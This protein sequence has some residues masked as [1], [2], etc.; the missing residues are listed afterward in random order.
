MVM[1]G[2]D[3]SN[4]QRGLDLAKM[5]V[6]FAI[7]K[8]T[9]GLDY[10]DSYCDGWVKQAKKLSMPWGFYHFARENDPVKE[11]D[12]FYKSCKN[13]FKSGIP[14]LDYETS[15]RNDVT[16]CEKFLERI[17]DLTGVWPLL[18]ISA[19]RVGTYF[20]SWIPDKCGLWIAGYPT[21][22]TDW[23]VYTNDGQDFS[24]YIKKQVQYDYWLYE[25]PPYDFG[26]WE[27]AAIWQFSSEVILSGYVGKLD[28]D[29]AYMDEN[30]WKKY[31]QGDNAK[32]TPTPKP[33][34]DKNTDE[35]A[36]E[37]LEGKHGTGA[38]RKKSLGKRY[39]EVQKR[40]D[41]LYNIAD[42]VIAGKWGNNETRKKK[43]KAAGYPYDLV[44][45]IVNEKMA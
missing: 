26:K 7:F 30:A 33:T 41:E 38:K 24:H 44:Q 39:D 22:Y 9:E 25:T 4:W 40:I 13:Y 15:N 17:H 32:P 31:A 10:V 16:W 27:C 2:I 37:V 18:Y 23:P 19:Y 1:R 14:V 20:N 36:R 8:A 45:K 3:I 21:T 6:D 29:L 28:G 35:L 42:E 34:Y 5:P 11:A 12:F 43:L